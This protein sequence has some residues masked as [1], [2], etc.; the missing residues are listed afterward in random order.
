MAATGHRPD[1]LGGYGD[2][3]YERLLSLAMR[4]IESIGPNLVIAGGALGWD[5][6]IAEASY[7]L[8]VPYKVYVPFAGQESKWPASAQKFYRALL[9]EASEVVECSE[10]G[11]SVAKMHVRN[12]RMVDDCD[13]LLALWDGSD[14]GTAS[15]VRY[16]KTVGRETINVWEQWKE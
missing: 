9:R 6:A 10:P 8:K 2:A 13:V 15:A 5:T 7:L 11:Y 16:A 12:H 1:K 14:G 3:V 4:S